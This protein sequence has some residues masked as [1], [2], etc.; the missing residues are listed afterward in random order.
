MFLRR[1][2]LLHIEQYG[3]VNIEGR[4][5]G[6]M[7]SR[8]DNGYRHMR[9]YQ[10]GISQDFASSSLSLAI[11]FSLRKSLRPSLRIRERISSEESKCL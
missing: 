5:L 4:L 1:V 10:M 7:S 2:L 9:K 3:H 8:R 6:I 11:S